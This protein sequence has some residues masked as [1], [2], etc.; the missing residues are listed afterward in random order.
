MATAQGMSGVDLLA[1]VADLR[2]AMP[3]WIGKVYQYDQKLLGL[4]LN[5]QEHA[6]YHLLAESGRRLHRVRTAPE[7]PKL[8]SSFAMLLRK[9]LEGGRVL[10]VEQHGL[11]RIVSFEVG[12]KET[13]YHLVFELFDEGNVVLC[14][15]DWTIVKP[16]WHHR[17]RDREVV[18]GAEYTLRDRPGPIPDAAGV[19]S[20]LAEADRDL[21]RTLATGLRLG[22][23]YAE[24]VCVRAGIDRSAMANAVDPGPVYAALE[25]LI[26]DVVEHPAPVLAAKG[27]WPIPLAGMKVD[28]AFPT[29]DEALEALYP[30]AP[31]KAA[32][33]KSEALS[34]EERIR[35][36]QITAVAGFEQ[37]IARYER[38]AQLVYEQYTLAAEVIT[39]LATAS[40]TRSWQEIARVL[41]G[42]DNPVAKRI[43]RVD[44]ATASVEVDLGGERVTLYVR[45]TVEQNV[46]RLYD[47]ARKFKK[48]RTGALAAMA[49]APP[50]VPP[51]TAVAAKREKPRWYHRFRWF[52][53]SDGALVLGG[54]DAGQNEELVKRYMEG[55]D[56]FVH[57]DVHGASVVIV[58][59]PTER[60][61]EVA[62][63]AASFSGAWR[64]GHLAADVYTARPDQVSK[65]PEAGEYVGRGSFIVRGE[66]TWFRS[67]PLGVAIGY[68]PTGVIG[69]PP[70]A[71][72]HRTEV[73]VLLRPGP[74][75]PNDTAR[76]VL[77]TLREH[78]GGDG[79]RSAKAVLNTEA[80]A[81]FVP[82][83]GSEVAEVH[84]G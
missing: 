31:P 2:R 76:Q 1:V 75:E 82:P 3:L 58:K 64:A 18:P 12:R 57:A 23:P 19:A 56:T 29:F 40:R 78:L 74:F 84:A 46:E 83:G 8:P 32:V 54:R 35:R 72:T 60:W 43:V 22:G 30:L 59:G 17:F 77:R 71:V 16:L 45:E 36:Q 33:A 51:K 38:L 27:A 11:E 63:F 73:R 13:S 48:K 39:T 42:A 66:R 34:R 69:G 44:P 24:E 65:T 81:R 6:R 80:V 47:Q 37:K 50:K 67:V 62:Q 20:L 41:K 15:A 49:A 52:E 53:T 61:D 4:R 5:G 25:S 55:K 7:P 9:H 79:G 28:A 26:C 70:S 10:A 14:D 68:G 21:V